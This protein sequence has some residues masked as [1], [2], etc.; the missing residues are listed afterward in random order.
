MASAAA[1]TI[2][3][4]EGPQAIQEEE[5][6]E[7]RSKPGAHGAATQQDDPEKGRLTGYTSPTYGTYPCYQYLL[8]LR[9]KA[10]A[11]RAAEGGKRACNTYRRH[12]ADVTKFR[13]QILCSLHCVMVGPP[14]RRSA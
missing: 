7:V 14:N 1:V 6:V 10:R 9:L 8:Y 4:G 3:V 2:D 12:S 13:I 5:S 11:H